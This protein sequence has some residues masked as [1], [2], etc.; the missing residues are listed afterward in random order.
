[1]TCAHSQSL[2]Y[3]PGIAQ[4][5]PVQNVTMPEFITACCTKSIQNAGPTLSMHGF[6][7]LEWNDR[8]SETLAFTE[9]D[10][11]DRARISW[12]STS[13]SASREAPQRATLQTAAVNHRLAGMTKLHTSVVL[14]LVGVC[15]L[16]A[17][18]LS[19]VADEQSC[20]VGDCNLDGVVTV[21]ELVAAANASLDGNV[22]GCPAADA[23]HDFKITVDEI[24]MAVTDALDG[25]Q[26]TANPGA[27]HLLGT[28][29]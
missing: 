26:F 18:Q 29:Q 8:Q 9:V 22:L 21:D 23:D 3:V 7:R 27:C 1:M 19:A 13:S 14:V 11:W 2:S 6:G 20:C 4:M 5:F 24:L 10:R 17:P 28:L 25:C 12:C 16:I 15:L